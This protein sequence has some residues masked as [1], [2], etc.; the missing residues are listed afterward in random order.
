MALPPTANDIKGQLVTLL[1]TPIATGK[2]AKILDYLPLAYLVPEGEDPTVLKSDLDPVTL[3]GGRTDRRINCVL[4]SEQGFTQGPAQ[5]D[6]TRHETS[7]RGRNVVSRRFYF[8]YV[9]QLGLD[10]EDT[11]STNLEL[12]RTTINANPKLGFETVTAGLAGQGAYIL[13]HGGLQMP[14]MLPAEFS[15]ILCHL[16]EGLL[17][18]RVIDPLG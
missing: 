7:P 5:R 13:D 15:G 6:A 9:Y 12:M 1:T 18:V 10:S 8:A 3:E 2:K 14:T 4:I 16:A 17:E 11:F